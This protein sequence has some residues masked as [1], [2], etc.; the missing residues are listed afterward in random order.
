MST[1]P[2]RVLYSFPHPLGGDQ[3][4]NETAWQHVVGLHALG[5]P[6]TVY[7]TSVRKPLPPGLRVVE[8]MVVAGRRVPHRA[9]GQANAYAYHDWRVAQ[10]LR[11]RGPDFDVV[12]CWPRAVLRTSRAARAAGVLSVRDVPSAHTATAF[13]D[14]ARA[15]DD[16]GVPVA[17]RSSH[18]ADPQRLAEEQAEFDAVDVLLVPSAYVERTF[19]ERGTRRERLVRQQYGFDVFRYA[20]GPPNSTRPF[21][22][23]FVGRGEAAKGLHLALDAWQR[24]GIGKRGRFVVAGSMQPEFAAHYAGQ[25]A[26][27][28][29]EVRGFVDSVAELMRECDVLLFPSYTE[30][31]ALVALEAMGSGVIPLV[32]AATGAPVTDGVDGLVHEVGD[33]DTLTQ[34]L[35]EVFDEPSRRRQLAAAAFRTSRNFTWDEAAKRLL[36]AYDEG[37]DRSGRRALGTPS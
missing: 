29:V 14:A 12:H 6:V 36:A 35:R 16:A 31:S 17:D 4:I 13:A 25:L 15:A 2:P 21:T 20:P 30:G 33:V 28:G 19:V 27:P 8:T 18:R 26:A 22:A 34:Q 9:V 10:V 23:V 11:R 37:V 5:V 24:S 1:A 3:G 32:S 7:C